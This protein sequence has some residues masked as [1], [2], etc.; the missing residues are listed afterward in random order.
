MHFVRPDQMSFYFFVVV[1]GAV[2]A[3]VAAST[4]FV[5]NHYNDVK[6]SKHTGGVLLLS[7]VYLLM[8]RLGAETGF[9]AAAPVPRLLFF[10]GG[11]ILGAI[12]FSFSKLGKRL[13]E[14]V[15]LILLVAF[16]IFRLPLELVLH[17][18]TEQG[19]IPSTMTWTGQ[20]FDIVTGFVAL[21]ATLI[22][23]VVKN[24]KARRVTAWTADV[25][26]IILL[27]NVMRV[28]IL[29][30]PVPF[31]WHLQSPLLVALYYPFVWIGPVCVGGALIGHILL[32]RRLLS[33]PL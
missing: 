15:P 5:V 20:N 8:Y 21:L 11:V 29:S 24:P 19:T 4:L 18:W 23:L 7:A 30:S 13:S 6:V 1:L 27:L 28:A 22:L 33:Y 9:F 32:T 14:H 26:G 10:F 12:A 2:I 16:Q 17:S 25:V 31:G 3:M